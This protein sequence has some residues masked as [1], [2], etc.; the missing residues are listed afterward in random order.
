MIYIKKM[1]NEFSH[2]VR[3]VSSSNSK[4]D[5]K[6]GVHFRLIILNSIANILNKKI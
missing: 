3:G 2:V 4:S 1:D 6:D 5:S